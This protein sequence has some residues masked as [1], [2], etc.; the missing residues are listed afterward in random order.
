VNVYEREGRKR[1]TER[2]KGG[3]EKEKE[4]SVVGSR[5]S[6]HSSMKE[7]TK[8]ALIQVDEHWRE[9]RCLLDFEPFAGR[10]RLGRS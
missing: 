6:S 5:F 4:K 1:E 9:S 2:E 7:P 3:G 10:C 8:P